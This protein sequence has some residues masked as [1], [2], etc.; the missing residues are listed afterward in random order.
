MVKPNNK[1]KKDEKDSPKKLS[2]SEFQNGSDLRMPPSKEDNQQILNKT[3]ELLQT[4]DHLSSGINSQT[5]LTEETSS[6]IQSLGTALKNT[7]NQT[8]SIGLAGEE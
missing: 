6:R 3:Q 8:Q 2:K 7:A 5:R 4:V 1:Q